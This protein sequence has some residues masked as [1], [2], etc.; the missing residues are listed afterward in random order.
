M[1]KILKNLFLQNISNTHIKFFG[2]FLFFFLL[3]LNSPMQVDSIQI[4]KIIHDF[5]NRSKFGKWSVVNDSVMGGISRSTFSFMPQ[6]FL[7]FEG[8]SG[9]FP[10]CPDTAHDLLDSGPNH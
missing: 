5:S 1:E 4:K 3:L 10:I 7:L 9:K 6:G 2:F 8:P